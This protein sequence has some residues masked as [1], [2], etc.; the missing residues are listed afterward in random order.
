[1]GEK[2]AFAT[3]WSLMNHVPN[4]IKTKYKMKLVIFDWQK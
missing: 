4:L 2:K 3:L 1:M